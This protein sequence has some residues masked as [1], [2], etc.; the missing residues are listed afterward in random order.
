M[1]TVLFPTGMFGSTIE[2]C[3][4]RFSEEIGMA[5]AEICND[6]SMHSF[7]KTNHLTE[8]TQPVNAIPD[9]PAQFNIL[10]PVYPPLDN[11]NLTAHQSVDKWSMILSNYSSK[12]IFIRPVT[13]SEIE[14]NNLFSF[15]KTKKFEKSFMHSVLALKEKNWNAEY[16]SWK[17]MKPWEV[18]EA[19]S[20]YCTDNKKTF[21]NI[22]DADRPDWL[23]I[24][25][26]EII[27]DFVSV[28]KK[29]FDFVGLTFNLLDIEEFYKEWFQKQQYVIKEY[30]LVKKIFNSIKKDNY[31]EWGSG[32]LSICSEAILQSNLRSIGI[33]LAC[34][35]LNNFPTNTTNLKK[36]FYKEVI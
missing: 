15:Y 7:N 34:A 33:D 4:R 5:D 1:I 31:L 20:F 19:L 28:I 11:Y 22:V 13:D 35:N 9:M 17:D 30:N 27:Y 36:F 25:A 14:R 24:G 8:F 2:F 29:I 16:T 32:E 10:T 12:V 18:R 3:L 6:G 26:D 23:C 21:S